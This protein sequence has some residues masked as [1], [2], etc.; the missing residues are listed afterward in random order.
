[1]NGLGKNAASARG[2]RF[3]LLCALLDGSA[4][5]F[6]K[7]LPWNP[8]VIAGLRGGLASLL[9][10][11][12]YKRQRI[13]IAV[14]GKSLLAGCM[15]SAMFIS[16]VTATRLTA[17]ANV[18]A[19]Q[20]CNPV[21]I[22]MFSFILFRQKPARFDLLTVFGALAGIAIIFSGSVIPGSAAGNILGLFSGLCLAGMLLYNNRVKDPA[23]HY[24]A[25]IL[26][27]AITF[28]AGIF[29]IF[30]YP[31]EISPVN[32]FAILGLGV[33]Q[34]MIPNI[35]YAYAIRVCRPLTCSLIMMLQLV[36]NP[37][38]VFLAVGEAPTLL[39]TLGCG[40]I[41][42]VSVWALVGSAKERG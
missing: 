27:H 19:L 13:K 10:L 22:V 34:Q 41:L 20:F 1:M 29:F 25:L 42:F 12:F 18:I 39:E 35:L 4:G 36:I 30:A 15:I 7:L 14:T 11:A 23:E 6:I 31:P 37:V 33:L 26:G 17:S 16:F 9:L 28:L 21:F 2:V 3:M 5:M 8:F 38:L 32:I 40:V 24:G